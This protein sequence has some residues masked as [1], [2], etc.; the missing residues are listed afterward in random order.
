MRNQ[1]EKKTWKK[2]EREC[3]ERWRHRDM[4]TDRDTDCLRD[5]CEKDVCANCE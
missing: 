1:G 4:L 3:G 2:E 5:I